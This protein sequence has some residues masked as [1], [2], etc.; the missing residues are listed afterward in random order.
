MHSS[1]LTIIIAL[2]ILSSTTSNSYSNSNNIMTP[3]FNLDETSP[4]LE[5][6]ENLFKQ[7]NQFFQSNNFEEAIRYYQQAISLNPTS[8]Q[9]HFNMGL[10]FLR[11]KNTDAA[12]ASFERAIVYKPSY[13]KAYANLGKILEQKGLKDQAFEQYKKALELDPTL[14]EVALALARSYSSQQNFH[15]SISILE[16]AL[17]EN[18][19]EMTLLFE[20]ANNLNMINQIEEA[21]EIYKRLEVRYPNQPSILYNIA[22]TLKKLGRL[23]EAFPYYDKVLRLNPTHAEAHFSRGLAY[24][25]TGDFEKGFKDYEWRW[26]KP[27][28]GSYRNYSE[29]RWDGSDLHG[30]TIFLHAEQGLG[31]TFQFVRYARLVKEKGGKVIVGA[32]KP[33][34]TLLRLCPYIDQVVA[35]NEALP[36]F[37]V[38]A[39]LMSLPYILKTTIDTVP[40]D[41]PYL[42]AKPELVEYWNK[43]LSPDKNFKIGICWQGNSKYSTPMLR[44]TV[45]LKSMNLNNFSLLGNIPGVSLYSLQ[46]TT[47]TEQ[48][49]SMAPEFTVHTFGD[50]FDEDNGRFMDTIAIIKN[51][52][53]VI[54]VDTSIGH[55]A[56]ALGKPTWIILPNPPDWRW[57]LNRDDTPW[58]PNVRLFRQPTPGDWEGIMKVVAQELEKYVTQGGQEDLVRHNQSI[59][60]KQAVTALKSNQVEIDEPVNVTYSWAQILHNL[61][62]ITVALHYV[63]DESTKKELETRQEQLAVHA[64]AILTSDTIVQLNKDLMA[65]NHRLWQTGNML[66]SLIDQAPLDEQFMSCVTNFYMLSELQ[67]NVLQKINV[68]QTH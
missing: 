21:L 61:S 64:Q 22:Y 58:Y 1:K 55:L 14:V 52:D 60:K 10:A 3:T 49:K 42:F 28:Q 27:Q 37:D 39:P 12:L 31:D 2:S 38:H 11:Q 63:T 56:A 19:T 46:K 62:M 68:L 18:A 65:I 54:T 50:N 40:T 48:L 34:V 67:K 41:I 13:S 26:K 35:L 43:R 7:A 17:K 15:E 51:L 30:K 24:I 44:A 6:F 8:A 23:E 53:L 4:S 57:M 45:A 59:Q 33:L 47:G 32:Q 36:P 20:L 5:S 25:V 9:T 16:T 29:P 66:R